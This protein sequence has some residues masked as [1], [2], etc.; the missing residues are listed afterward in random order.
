MMIQQSVG[1]AERC[2]G[3]STQP[4]PGPGIGDSM[5]PVSGSREPGCHATVQ[6]VQPLSE[7]STFFSRIR[8]VHFDDTVT[9]YDCPFEDRKAPW[10]L[11]ARKRKHF[12]H[13]IRQTEVV[14]RRVLIL[15]RVEQYRRRF[16]ESF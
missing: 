10:M 1:N 6:R 4:L 5:L 2:R 15:K 3:K 13:R 16:Y 11:Y 9:V 12:E 8:H 7:H 14:L